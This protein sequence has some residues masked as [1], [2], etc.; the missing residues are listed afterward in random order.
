MGSGQYPRSWRVL[1]EVCARVEPPKV[2]GDQPSR[3]DKPD[4][5][6]RHDPHDPPTRSTERPN[7]RLPDRTNDRPTR[8]ADSAR[9]GNDISGAAKAHTVAATHE[10]GADD[11]A[12]TSHGVGRRSPL[13]SQEPM[14]STRS[15][16]EP[17]GPPQPIASP[18]PMAPPQPMASLQH[19]A[20]ATRR[21]AGV[22]GAEI[23]LEWGLFGVNFGQS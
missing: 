5:P 11:I 10:V 20:A 8:P 21:V 7:D 14:G 15:A 3:T 2:G 16:P 19:I 6:N 4:P 18:Q 9:T 23:E 13:A 12:A 1:Q 17:M 22:H